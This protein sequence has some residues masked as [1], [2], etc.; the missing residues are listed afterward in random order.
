MPLWCKV[1]LCPRRCHGGAPARHVATHGRESVDAVAA[2][3]VTVATTLTVLDQH[4]PAEPIDQL[5]AAAWA[6]HAVATFHLRTARFVVAFGRAALLSAAAAAV[7]AA[8]A[9]PA[10]QAHAATR[11]LAD[12]QQL[13]VFSVL[14]FSLFVATAFTST[15][16][17]VAAAVVGAPNATTDADAHATPGAS[18]ARARRWVARVDAGC[19]P[20][21]TAAPLA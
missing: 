4:L 9:T 6:F 7:G 18:V 2:A 21:A 20:I 19:Q 12:M 1:P 5:L 15:A 17:G 8:V 14:F 3:T 10:G 13:R 16:V 11:R